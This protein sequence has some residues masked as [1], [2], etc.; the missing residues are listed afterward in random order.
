MNAKDYKFGMRGHDLDDNLLEMCENAKKHNVT[1][2][3]FALA[4]TVN[5]KDFYEI[6]YDVSL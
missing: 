4:K 1:K 5:D 3:Q 2:L 6:G